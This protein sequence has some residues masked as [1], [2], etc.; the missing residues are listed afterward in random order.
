MNVDDT[1]AGSLSKKSRRGKDADASD[2]EEPVSSPVASSPLP[3]RSSPPTEDVKEVTTGVKEIELNQKSE[4]PLSDPSEVVEPPATLATETPTATDEEAETDTEEDAT[5]E[6]RS[7][8]GNTPDVE[9]SQDSAKGDITDEIPVKP[10][11]EPVDDLEDTIKDNIPLSSSEEGTK[12]LTVDSASP[13]KVSQLK[14]TV[15][16]PVASGGKPKVRA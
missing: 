7:G 13:A 14:S 2:D 1:P 11:Q 15:E 12:P 10:V 3:P 5:P 4:A 9:G 8:E 16:E 6:Q